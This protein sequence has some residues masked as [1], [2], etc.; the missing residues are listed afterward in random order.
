MNVVDFEL[1]ARVRIASDLYTFPLGKFPA[2]A[3]GTVIQVSRSAHFGQPI[4]YV[5]MDDHFDTLDAWNNELQVNR[6]ADEVS[7]V[8]ELHF[9]LVQPVPDRQVARYSRHM[10]RELRVIRSALEVLLDGCEEPD[11]RTFSRDWR[12]DLAKINAELARRVETIPICLA[13]PRGI[14][15]TP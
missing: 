3:A 1:G 2:G 5:E 10:T 9:E 8:N 14:E 15:V 7:D 4:A 6:A 12:T 11:W 13:G